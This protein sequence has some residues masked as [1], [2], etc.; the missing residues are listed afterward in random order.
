MHEQAMPEML[1]LTQVDTE[2]Q[3]GKEA[4]MKKQQICKRC[5]ECCYG[6]QKPKCQ[7]YVEWI[8]GECKIYNNN[9]ELITDFMKHFLDRFS[10]P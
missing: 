8:V 9:H 6:F 4:R 10:P 1:Q 3:K 5:V 2:D 7:H